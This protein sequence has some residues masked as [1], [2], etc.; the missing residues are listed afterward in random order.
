MSRPTLETVAAAAGVSRATVSRVIRQDP[1]VARATVEKVHRAIDE[2]AYV[3]NSSARALASGTPSTVALIV[4]EPDQRVF[5]DPFFQLAISGIT[6]G[7]RESPFQFVMAFAPTSGPLTSTRQFLSSGAIAGA[8]VMSHHRADGLATAVAALP[9]PSVFIGAPLAREQLPDSVVSVDTDN[10]AGSRLAGERMLAQGV[11]H[12]ATIAGPLDMTAAIDR[13]SGWRAPLEAAGHEPIVVEGDFTR[14]TSARLTRDLLRDHPE[15]D[16]IFAASDLMA[17]G[18]LD[19]L[20]T[21]G[22]TVGEDVQVVGYDDFSAAEEVGLTTVHNP[23][24]QLG[25]EGA[26]LLLERIAHP[27]AS[28]NSLVLPASLVVRTTG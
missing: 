6:E 25:E 18:V 21:E 5:S 16:G 7:L 17:L 10:L 9:L 11:R 13:L 2:L 24:V 14:A 28:P 15:V 27:A 1:N 19:A 20:R 12:P 4:P 26:R 8:L 22:R 3:P 23:A